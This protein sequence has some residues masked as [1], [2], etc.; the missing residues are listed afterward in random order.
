MKSLASVLKHYWPFIVERRFAIAG[1]MFLYG[2]GSM[3]GAVI[4]PLIYKRIIDVITRSGGD[5]AAA[6]ADL[7]TA[8]IMLAASLISLQIVFRVADWLGVWQQAAILKRLSDYVF[9]GIQKH[10]YQFFVNSFAG[11]LVAKSKRFVDSFETLEDTFMFDVWMNGLTVVTILVIMTW[12]SP[13]LGAL[14][15]AWLIVYASMT[16]WFIRRKIP[17]DLALAAARTNTTGALADAITNVL[18]IKMFASPTREVAR[19]TDVTQNETD[20]RY[21]SWYFANTQRAAQGFFMA[22]FQIIAIVTVSVLW[23]KGMVTAGTVVLVQIYL[24]KLFDITWNLG[25]VITRAI[26]AITDA[27]EMVEILDTPES[28]ADS[29]TPEPVRITN[30]AITFNDVT[31]AYER[32]APVFENFSLSIRA[33]EKVGLV[34]HSGAGKTTITKLLLRFA[35]VQKGEICIDGQNIAHITQDDLRSHIAYVPQEPLLFHRALRENIAYGKP[36]ASDDEI[37][38]VA[39]RARAHEFI[40]K[41]PE[42]YSTLV[43][44][45]GVKLSGGERQ[46]VA[47]ARAMLKDAPILILDEATSSLDSM[48]EKAIQEAFAELMKGK[49]ALV[50]AHRLSTIRQMDRIL[51][52]NDGSIVEEG[53]HDELVARGGVYAELWKEQA[54]GFIGE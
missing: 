44:E 47:I 33:G 45:R 34:G 49:T 23:L 39:Q 46:R 24:M 43:G 30:G 36:D 54:G 35:D 41:L 10:S 37:T 25:R 42:G 31:F 28:V 7:T 51:V 18:T 14:Y 16:V 48:S 21:S 8:L 3:L 52:F 4:N 6:S 32:G 53:T 11:S 13:I 15:I 9:A 20:K 38:E 17:R 19:F 1:T 50:V 22:V 5:P 2:V 12:L 40:Q 27:Q 26:T 29:S